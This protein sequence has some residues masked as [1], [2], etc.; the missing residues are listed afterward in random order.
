MKTVAVIFATGV[1]WAVRVLFAWLCFATGELSVAIVG[2]VELAALAAGAV[3]CFRA[4]EWDAGLASWAVMLHYG[5]AFFIMP[6]AA[7]SWPL[8]P[9]SLL[10]LVCVIYM[11]SACTTGALNWV[12][13]VERGPFRLVR[14]PMSAA[15]VVSRIAMAATWPSWWNVGVVLFHVAWAWVDVR[16][17]ERWLARRDEWIA[18]ALRVR[19]RWCPYIW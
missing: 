12:G 2:A 9:I 1:L 5:S 16:L 17:E 18:Y 19:W 14:H 10:R 3:N 13:L 11:G 4:R 6:Q 7:T 15:T 8:V